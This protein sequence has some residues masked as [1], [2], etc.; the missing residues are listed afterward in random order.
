MVREVRATVGFERW[1]DKLK[2]RV[3]KQRIQSRMESAA[4]GHFGDHRAVGHGVLELRIHLGPGYRLY[5]TVEI[6]KVLFF[7]A[8]GDKDS[9]QADIKKAH[10]LVVELT[11]RH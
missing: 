9:Q 5:C 6:D 8:G 2:D 7:L 3:A 1:R 10:A 4:S 11:A